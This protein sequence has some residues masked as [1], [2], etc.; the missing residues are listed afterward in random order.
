MECFLG[1]LPVLYLTEDVSQGAE[2]SVCHFHLGLNLEKQ[3]HLTPLEVSP[4]IDYGH[5]P[6][7]HKLIGFARVAGLE[8]YISNPADEN[9]IKEK[10]EKC[11]MNRS[12]V[13]NFLME[14]N[15]EV[16]SLV[17]SQFDALKELA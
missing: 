4:I 8:D 10:V 13:R 9:D 7:A 2:Q 3:V 17:R 5:E 6:K 11:W 1:F 14:R 15:N 12:G 16:A